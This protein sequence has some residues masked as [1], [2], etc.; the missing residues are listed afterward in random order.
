QLSDFGT[1]VGFGTKA[2]F[3][4]EI[5]NQKGVIESAL[6]KAFSPEFLNRIDDIIMFNPLS[7]EDIHKIIELELAKL[8]T[9]IN[10]LGYQI[11]LTDDA[12]DFIAEKGW[13]QKFGARPLKRAIQ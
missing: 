5:A 13:D 6:K 7:K 12:R 9:R 11:K 3:E 10:D 8:Y 4:N 2:R 1:G